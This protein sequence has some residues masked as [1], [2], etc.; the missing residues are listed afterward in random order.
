MSLTQQIIMGL[1]LYMFIG[2]V[3][4]IYFL[5]KANKHP[6]PDVERVQAANLIKHMLFMWPV[7]LYVYVGLKIYGNIK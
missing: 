7:H 5:T 3:V 4:G 2:M 1:S 6:D